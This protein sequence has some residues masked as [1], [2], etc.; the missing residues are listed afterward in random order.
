V[1][2]FFED[3]TELRRVQCGAII[4]GCARW[5]EYPPHSAVSY[6]AAF[7]AGE[8]IDELPQS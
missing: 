6:R 8:N 3:L 5:L 2:N 4:E 7:L 1:H